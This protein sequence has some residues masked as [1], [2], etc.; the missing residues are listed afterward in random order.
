M[1]PMTR[2]RPAGCW[3]FFSCLLGLALCMRAAQADGPAVGLPG[4]SKALLLSA[5][6]RD[7]IAHN[8]QVIVASVQYPLYLFKDEQGQWSGLNHDILVQLSRMTGLQFVHEESFSTEHLLGLLESG[9]ANM[10]TTLAMNEERKA[11]LDFSHAFGGS[12]W[13]FVERA[14]AQPV[15]SLEALQGKVLALPARHALESAIRHEYPQIGLRSVKTYA[16][17]RALVETGE[18]DATIEN[19]NAIY[20]FPAGR[21]KIGA[22]LEGKWEHDHLALRKGQ[23]QLLSILNKALEALPPGELQGIRTKWLEGATAVAPS[24]WQ[25]M[26]SWLFWGGLLMGVFGLISVSWRQRLNIQVQKRKA[27]EQALDDQLVFQHSLINAMPDPMFVRDLQGRLLLCNKGYEEY[28]SVRLERVQ[29]KCLTDMDVLPDA[30]ARLLHAE[31]MEQLSSGKSRFC[32]RQLMLKDGVRGIYQWTVPFYSAS[33][34]LRGV[35]GGWTEPRG[36]SSGS[37]D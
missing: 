2:V 31:M 25:W 7:W 3:L 27:A 37:A 34:E 10:S 29:G 12:G 35:V 17:A 30:T 23:P 13:V 28:L 4:M 9:R 36:G 24:P 20:R 15:E 22:S 14:E 16:E 26:Y 11:Y 5:S 19:D 6:E 32:E 33:G 1:W 8:R 21:L 18:A